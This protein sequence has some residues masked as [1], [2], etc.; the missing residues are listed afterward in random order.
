MVTASRPLRADAAR[1]REK[2]LAAA[3]QLFAERGLDVPLE[4]IARRA[5]VSIGTLY[6]HFPTREAF[7]AAI[8]PERLAALDVIGEK[9]LA[10][11]DPWQ[12]FAGYLEDL[13]ALQAEDRGLNDVLARDLPNAPEVVSAC[14]RGAG[15]AEILIARGVEAGVLRPDYSIADVATLTRAMAQVIRD[16]PSEWRRFLSIYVEGLRT[17]SP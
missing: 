4:H 5:E 10:T 9:A 17:Q 15:H 12:A 14:H 16:S 13:Y 3:A 6:K 2:L 7:V 1:N 11:P 8:F